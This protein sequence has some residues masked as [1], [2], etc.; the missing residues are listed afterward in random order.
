V[1]NV[2]EAGS[3]EERGKQHAVDE[4]KLVPKP[5]ARATVEHFRGVRAPG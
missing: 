5:P 2:R 1:G 4:V 3:D